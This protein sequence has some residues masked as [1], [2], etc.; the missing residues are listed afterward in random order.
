MKLNRKKCQFRIFEIKFMG[1]IVSADGPVKPDRSKID[2]VLNMPTLCD[3]TAVERL[4]DTVAFLARFIPKFNQ[5]VPKSDSSD[6]TTDT[7]R[8]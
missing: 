6:I 8:F 5:L 4:K 3:K 1:H 7:Q 2:T